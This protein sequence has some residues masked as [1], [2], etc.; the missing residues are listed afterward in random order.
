MWAR[1][2]WHGRRDFGFS[3]HRR[4]QAA[5]APIQ[6]GIIHLQAPVHL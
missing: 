5:A 2:N 3:A 6:R 1:K 4:T